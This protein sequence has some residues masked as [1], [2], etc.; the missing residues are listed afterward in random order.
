MYAQKYTY[1]RIYIYIY[2]YT[3]IYTNEYISWREWDFFFTRFLSVGNALTCENS[4]PGALFLFVLVCERARVCGYGFMWVS[5][6]GK[7]L[8]L[9]KPT[10][11]RDAQR[12][13]WQNLDPTHAAWGNVVGMQIVKGLQSTLSYPISEVIIQYAPTLVGPGFDQDGHE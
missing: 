13:D 4:T 10:V 2:I 7:V 11:F 3:C 9:V 12:I 8:K 1:M 6:S 5:H